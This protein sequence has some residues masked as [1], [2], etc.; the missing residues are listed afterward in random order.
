[1]EIQVSISN[2]SKTINDAFTDFI[3]HC[4]YEKGLNKKTINAYQIDLNQLVQY[5]NKT[6]TTE[7]MEEI[8]KGMIKN[9]LQKISDF[10]PKTVKRKI[11]SMKVF[12]S[13]YEFENETFINPLRKIK[14]HLKEPRILPSVMSS[15]EVKAILKFLYKER[16]NNK[17]DDGYTYKAQTRNIAI[18]ELLFATGI[19]VSEL[20]QLQNHNVDLQ[21]GIIKVYGKGNKERIIQICSKEVISILKEYNKL[22]KPEAFFFVN[23][24][25]HEISPQSVRLLVKRCVKELNLSKHI[26]PHTFR[27]TFATLLLEE[28]VD[29][30]YIQILLGHSSIVTT[31]IYTHVNS[32]KQKDILSK[33]H[34]RNRFDINS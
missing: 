20:C 21:Q 1:M 29:I 28:G 8:S 6:F 5:L 31:Q 10:Q 23:R 9:Y 24:L 19:R 34:P 32:N 17:N 11:A 27:H 12:F 30:K 33:K 16:M 14:I 13:F 2:A 26:T 22:F 7:K 18:I 15:S 3:F 4:Q 25:G